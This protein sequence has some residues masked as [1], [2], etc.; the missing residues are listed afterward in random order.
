VGYEGENCYQDEGVTKLVEG[1]QGSTDPSYL[2][3]H[4]GAIEIGITILFDGSTR[5]VERL[6]GRKVLKRLRCGSNDLR[7][8][9]GR[10]D[11]LTVDER[12][13]RLCGTGDVESEKHFLIDCNY[14]QDERTRLW[15]SLDRL[16]NEDDEDD[17]EST[18]GHSVSSPFSVSSLFHHHQLSLMMGGFHPRI[19]GDTLRERVMSTIL[20]AIG[21]WYN[22]RTEWM[23][24]YNESINA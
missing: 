12:L 22:K 11:G 9:T 21:D 2:H 3:H 16:V 19:T 6:I 10:W 15:E 23:K 18:T 17:D 20:I 13:C 8:D 1:S 24:I 5:R 4:Q 7:I 14:Y